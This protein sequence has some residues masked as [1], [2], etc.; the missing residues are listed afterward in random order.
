[1]VMVMISDDADNG[2]EEEYSDLVLDVYILRSAVRG[3]WNVLLSSRMGAYLLCMIYLQYMLIWI[4][5]QWCMNNCIDTEIYAAIVG[6][7]YG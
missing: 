5:R 3:F 6:M 1:M 7:D 4:F 2:D